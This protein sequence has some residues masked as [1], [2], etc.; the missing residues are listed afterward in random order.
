MKWTEADGVHSL[1]LD[2]E[3]RILVH[4][5]THYGPKAWCVTCHGVGF[6]VRPLTSV[7]LVGAQYEAHRLVRGRLRALVDYYA[8]LGIEL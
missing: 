8:T 5:H 2:H 4:H 3:L 1:G 6:D 7:S